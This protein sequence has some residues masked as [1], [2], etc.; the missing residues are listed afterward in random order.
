MSKAVNVSQQVRTAAL[1]PDPAYSRQI[2][3][4]LHVP[5]GL[6]AEDFCFTP[7]LGNSLILYGIDLWM[8]CPDPP[9]FMGGFIYLMSGTGKP[10]TAGKMIMGWDHIVPLS[11][12][13]KP[14]IGLYYCSHTEL[15][16]TMKKRYMFDA[17]RFGAAAEN[18]FNQ[19]WDATLLF[20]ISEG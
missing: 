15:H 4:E 19:D 10:S 16:F 14:G 17:I 1:R 20:E 8:R 18:G 3:L 2:A 12:G 6:G 7:P 11:C 9:A 13:V 5:A